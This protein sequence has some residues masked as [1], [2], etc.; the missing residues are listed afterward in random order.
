[1]TRSLGVMCGAALALGV[2]FSTGAVAA[3]AQDEDRR[4]VAF[5]TYDEVESVLTSLGLPHL[6]VKDQDGNPYISVTEPESKINFAIALTVCQ[7]AGCYGM[8]IDT[9]YNRGAEIPAQVINEFDF[10]QPFIAAAMLNAS[11]AY[12][13]RYEI[14][15]FGIP[16]GNIASNIINFI[17]IAKMLPGF[18][19]ANG[20]MASATGLQPDIKMVP[21]SDVHDARPAPTHSWE[22]IPHVRDAAGQSDE[23]PAVRAMNHF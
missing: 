1:M 21:V 23:A 7:G 3:P 16:R 5:F 15:D 14:A 22:A 20:T 9:A 6:R 8:L 10:G 12:I 13:S 17:E 11:T 18:I 2:A 4:I 19:E